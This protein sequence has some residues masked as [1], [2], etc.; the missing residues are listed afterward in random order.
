MGK[1]FL[2]QKADSLPCTKQIDTLGVTLIEL[3]V[4]NLE[5][6]GNH[7]FGDGAESIHADSRAD[8]RNSLDS[9]STELLVLGSVELG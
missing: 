8:D 4:L 7:A 5:D 6:H 1:L 2:H 9:L 3:G